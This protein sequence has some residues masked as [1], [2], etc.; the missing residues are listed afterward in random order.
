MRGSNPTSLAWESRTVPRRSVIAGSMAIRSPDVVQ[1]ETATTVA[2]RD[3]GRNTTARRGATPGTSRIG[4]SARTREMKRTTR[5]E[6][7]L[8]IPA[9]VDDGRLAGR[10]G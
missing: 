6:R 4:A 3:E 7:V 10:H 1:K 2:R 8:S 9:V 5:R